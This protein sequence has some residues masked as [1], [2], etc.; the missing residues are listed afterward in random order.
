[1]LKKATKLLRE[2]NTSLL[3]HLKQELGEYL[4]DVDWQR[5]T[6]AEDLWGQ[7]LAKAADGP[8][9]DGPTSDRSA[10]MLVLNLQRGMRS[11]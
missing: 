8:E 10:W 7:E 9:A 5:V 3:A 6:E 1:M 11:S 4:P 2:K